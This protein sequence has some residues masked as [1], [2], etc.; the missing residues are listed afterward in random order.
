MILLATNKRDVTT[1]FIVRELKN[2]NLPF[3]RL[4]TEDIGRWQMQMAAGDPANLSLELGERSL[5]LDDVTAAYYRRP[6][7]PEF[8]EHSGAAREYLQAEWSAVLRSLWNALEG[9]WLNSPFAILRAEDKPRQLS[10]AK[11]SAFRIPSTVVTNDPEVAR[12]FTT[13]HSCIAKP[14]RQA[15]L[16]EGNAGKV[17][18]TSRI[19]TM[20]CVSDDEI[21]LA[22]VIYQQEIPKR[23]DVRVIVVD[24]QVFATAIES[25]QWSETEVDWR[26]GIRTDLEHCTIELPAEVIQACIAVTMA[27][28]LRYSAIDLVEDKEGAFW[29]L[30]A[31]PNGQWAWIEQRTGA[32]VSAAIVEALSR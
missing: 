11:R 10:F 28:G 7:P 4:N 13:K 29:F 16:D 2:R 19:E 25:Q 30:E 23:R 15:L 32:P 1:D 24:Q 22:P 12:E 9:R 14:L 5:R 31:N 18:F 3:L 6:Q 26:K 27:L 21:R 17:I 8:N 20:D